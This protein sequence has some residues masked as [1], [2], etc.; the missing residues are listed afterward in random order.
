MILK[1]ARNNMIFNEFDDNMQVNWFDLKDKKFLNT[2]DTLYYSVFTTGDF[3]P[4]TRDKNVL[5]YR[6]FWERELSRLRLFDDYT[7]NSIPGLPL[8]FQLKY[9]SFG[10]GTYEI[11]LTRP[12]HY[13]ILIAKRTSNPMTSQILVQLRSKTLWMDSV[14]S[15]IDESL[16]DVEKIVKH[17]RFKI[18]EV[19]ENRIDYCW[20]T[21]Y[22]QNPESYFLPDNFAKMR[23]S[24]MDDSLV[25]VKYKGNNDYEIDYVT[26]GCKSSANVF[27][28]IYLKSKEVVEKGYKAFFLK[29]WYLNGMISRYDLYCYEYAYDNKNWDYLN[30]G[31]LKFYLEHGS[32]ILIKGTCK[33]ILEG[34]IKMKY[35]DLKHFADMITPAVTLVINVEYQTMRKFSQSVVL[36]DSTYNFKKWGVRSRLYDIVDN[37]RYIANYLVKHCVRFVTPYGDKN[38]SRREDCPFWSCLARSRTIDG[39]NTPA[40]TVAIRQYDHE[41]NAELVKKRALGSIASFNLYRKGENQEDVEQDIVD[42]ISSLND[43]DFENMKNSK[44][45]KMKRTDYSSPLSSEIINQTKFI[46]IDKDSGEVLNNNIT[47]K[48]ILQDGY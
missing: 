31:R 27:F 30:L 19:K 5:Y 2:I 13:D 1:S 11:C 25:H 32:D 33:D 37:Y 12:D 39:K 17:F 9:C 8:Y 16:A 3:S 10:G 38:K 22:I 44:N 21:N 42:F 4:N 40:D 48:E 46:I 36:P 23:L 41:R 7:I 6:R 24:R 20:H 45:K 26:L 15:A 43:N 47:D 34:K 28:R 14:R 18:L 35:D 29:I